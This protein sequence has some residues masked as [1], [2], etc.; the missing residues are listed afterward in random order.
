[1][2]KRDGKRND[3]LHSF[4]RLLSFMRRWNNEESKQCCLATSHFAADFKVGCKVDTVTATELRRNCQWIDRAREKTAQLVPNVCAADLVYVLEGAGR[5]TLEDAANAFTVPS[6]SCGNDEDWE[7]FQSHARTVE[8]I[9]RAPE[10]EGIKELTAG[11]RVGRRCTSE[12]VLL[13]RTCFATQ[14]VG[15]QEILHENANAHVACK[16]ESNKQKL[17]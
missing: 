9:P 14:H 2:N 13:V 1:M 7:T 16:T 5:K 10:S 8:D 11:A 17:Q 15:P 3:L 6:V 12:S 4:R